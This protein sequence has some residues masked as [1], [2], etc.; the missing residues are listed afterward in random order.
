MP[1]VEFNPGAF[2]PVVEIVSEND[3]TPFRDMFLNEDEIIQ[4]LDVSSDNSPGS[5]LSVPANVSCFTPS[6]EPHPVPYDSTGYMVGNTCCAFSVPAPTVHSCPCFIDR[7]NIVNLPDPDNSLVIGLFNHSCSSCA[8]CQKVKDLQ[9]CEED[10]FLTSLSPVLEV[11]TD[12]H[13]TIPH[14]LIYGQTN[15]KV[16]TLNALMPSRWYSL[17][18]QRFRLQILSD[19]HAFM[20]SR[21]SWDVRTLLP[22]RL[23]EPPPTSN[24]CIWTATRSTKE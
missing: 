10:L 2:A 20:T 24:G 1:L 12:F 11:L 18:E 17:R 4:P 7:F 8:L 16:F 6:F 22:L 14:G 9:H 15:R 3:F 21:S 23:H 5:V 19:K 13:M